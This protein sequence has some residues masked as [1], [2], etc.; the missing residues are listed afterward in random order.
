MLCAWLPLRLVHGLADGLGWLMS[1]RPTRMR[2]TTRQNLKLCFPDL[3]NEQL[4]L[5]AR[6]SL[7][8]TA[9]TAVEMGRCWLWPIEKILN[10]VVEIDGEEV[11]NEARSAGKGVIILAPH[12]GNWEVLGHYFTE[13]NPTTFLYQPSKNEYLDKM[14]KS[15]RSGG[16]SFLAPT[17][18]QGVAMLLKTLKKGEQVGILPD[19]EP[20]QE[21]GE[22]ATFFGV[23]AFTM[24]LVTRL[25]A[26]TGARVIC[27]YAERLPKGRGFKLHIKHAD[28]MIYDADLKVSVEGLNRTVEDC[29]KQSVVQYQWEYKRFKRRLDGSHFYQ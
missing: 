10:M 5:M 9:K 15:A 28:P 19:Q 23:P 11:L 21:G 17:N 18:R 6:Q 27:G 25:V 20:T 8:H 22:F 14:I 7:Q 26:R 12:L 13:Q 3:D 2:K 4:T 1:K 16:K 29:V 24:T